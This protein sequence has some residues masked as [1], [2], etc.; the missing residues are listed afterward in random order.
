MSDL[1]HEVVPDEFI[2]AVFDT[3][4]SAE[5]HTFQVLT[6]RPDRAAALSRSLPW[7][8]NVWMGTSIENQRFVSRSDDLRDTGAVTKF[9]SCEP[10]LGPLR[11][12]LCDIDWVI[13]GGESGFRARPMRADWARDI[14]D[15]CNASET[16]FFFKQWG[17]HDEAGIR[18]GKHRSGR[19]LDGRTWDELP[20]RSQSM[21]S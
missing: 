19:T 11:L 1:F 9:L 7:P 13:V 3:M 5:R 16:A 2:R 17:A 12:D 20:T 18:V 6:K 15:Q 14:R 4:V 8:R 21:S 10:L